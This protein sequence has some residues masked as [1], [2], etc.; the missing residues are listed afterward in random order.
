LLPIVS[1]VLFSLAGVIA[2]Y[3]FSGMIWGV[4]YTPTANDEIDRATKL[5]D[6][7][8]GDTI[9]DLGCGYGR[10]IFRIAQ[11]YNVN[12]VGVEADPLKCWWIK[13][14]IKRKKLEGRVRLM[15]AN[16]LDVDLKGVNNVYIFL[17]RITQIMIK[18]QKK[19][20]REMK[21]GARI[22]SY[23]HKFDHWE[24]DENLGELYLYR[25]PS[26]TDSSSRASRNA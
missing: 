14:M 1:I 4:G 24:P 6:L 19:I 13:Q 7:K 16:L 25:I 9:Y 26:K 17:T 11:K 3:F 12:C 10:V 8:E 15:Q 23:V 20:L 18:L 21:P 22:V 2:F 5:L